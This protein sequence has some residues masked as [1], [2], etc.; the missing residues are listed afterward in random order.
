MFNKIVDFIRNYYLACTFTFIVLISIVCMSLTSKP[1]S[2]SA[3]ELNNEIKEECI[4]E[5]K[6][7]YVLVDIKGAVKKPGVYRLNINSIINDVINEA[8]GLLKTATTDDI[9][10]SKAIYNEM[11][12]YVSTKSE[13]KEKQNST[14]SISPSNN[15]STTV[16]N[17]TDTCISTKVN[18][19]T[20]SIEELTNIN[21]IG[22]A[23]AQKIVEYRQVNGSFKSVEDIKNVSGIGDAFYDKIKDY[24]TI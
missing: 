5:E 12:I 19:N 8:G 1:S 20:A 24:I 10:L 17:N 14:N 2:V 13:L 18:I 16:T 22:E 15:N 9:N 6:E 23:K 3:Q 11:V 21:G 7:E 4:C